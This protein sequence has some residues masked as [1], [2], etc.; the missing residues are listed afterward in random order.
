[1][2]ATV[3]LIFHQFQPHLLSHHLPSTPIRNFEAHQDSSSVTAFA[4]NGVT[5]ITGVGGSQEIDAGTVDFKGQGA[6]LLVLSLFI[7]TS[8][9]MVQTPNL[10]KA[11]SCVAHQYPTLPFPPKF[12]FPSTRLPSREQIFSSLHLCYE[13]NQREGKIVSAHRARSRDR[14][15]MDG[16]RTRRL[17]AMGELRLQP[18][19]VAPLA[20]TCSRISG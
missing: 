1:M 2:A 11:H 12:N 18:T 10:P 9:L 7:K 3:I 8:S 17:S 20:P 15:P 4:W 13:L 14:D 16:T 5:L 19:K 6:L